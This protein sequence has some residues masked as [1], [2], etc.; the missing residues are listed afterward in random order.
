M[1]SQQ[2]LIASGLSVQ[3][4]SAR[5]SCKEDAKMIWKRILDCQGGFERLNNTILWFRAGVM[6]KA[7]G[8]IAL[9]LADTVLEVFKFPAET[10]DPNGYDGAGVTMDR[11]KLALE[12]LEEAT[13]EAG[14][15]KFRSLATAQAKLNS[16][17]FDAAWHADPKKMKEALSKGAHVF[18]ITK[19]GYPKTALQVAAKY[20]NRECCEM[21]IEAGL[22]VYERNVMRSDG[23]RRK[24][25]SWHAI[26]YASNNN[27]PELA[28]WLKTFPDPHGD[29]QTRWNQLQKE[30]KGNFNVA[31]AVDV[32]DLLGLPIE[33]FDPDGYDGAGVT[34]DQR[35]LAQAALNAPTPEEGKEMLRSLAT[36]QGILNCKIF[37]A[38]WHNDPK[39]MRSALDEKADAFSI[40]KGNNPKTALQIAAKYGS[41]D[42]CT[43]LIRAGLSP[44]EANAMQSDGSQRKIESWNAIRYAQENKHAELAEWMKMFGSEE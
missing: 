29:A 10:V 27:H 1:T 28:D 44:H 36:S 2:A 12:V 33:T 41:R 24:I 38:A 16:Q 32:L 11:R 39:L 20:G 30:N 3:T 14:K 43:M 5:C 9:E 8:D 4:L 35:K 37:A 42:C 23:S 7:G 18:C 15:E 31:V 21:L 6:A 40:T 13:A 22:D 34:V 26:Q 17:I 25:E 19:G